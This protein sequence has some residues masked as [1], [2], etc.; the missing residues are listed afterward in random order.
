MNDTSTGIYIVNVTILTEGGRNT[1]YGHVARCT[2]IYQAF[3]E[4]GITPEF[5]VHGE[6][7]IE[8]LLKGKRYRFLDWINNSELLFE[9]L[10]DC[11]IVFIDSYLASHEIYVNVSKHTKRAVYFD[12]D[13]RIDYPKG[14]VVN[15][16]ISAEQLN[17]PVKEGVTYLLGTSYFPLRKEFSNVPAKEIRREVETLMVTCGGSDM[18][19]VTPVIQALLNET[20]P[21]LQKKI[22]VTTLFSNISEIKKLQDKKTELL[23][24]LN[25]IDFKAVMQDS[26]IAISTGG[27]TLYE[28]AS[29]GLPTIAVCVAENQSQNV[30]GWSKTGNMEYADMYEDKFFLPKLKTALENIMPY[31]KRAGYSRGTRQLVD[32]NGAMRVCQTLLE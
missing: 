20:Y 25:A 31:E 5:I 30:T 8:S 17:Y 18:H 6:K 9:V 19:N 1:G 26:D 4:K 10:K 24:D 22:V 14:I 7:H 23:C 29:V 16:A 15:G 11:N 27:Q 28:L 32:G 13:L 21:D 3:E 2:S 12:D